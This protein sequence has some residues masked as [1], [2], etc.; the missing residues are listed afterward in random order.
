[1]GIDL[2]FKL[3]ELAVAATLAK[4][5]APEEIEAATGAAAVAGDRPFFSR[6]VFRRT[7]SV[8]VHGD[9]GLAGEN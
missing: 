9:F 3:G 8:G 5:P 2:P 6:R 4:A 1:V 7:S